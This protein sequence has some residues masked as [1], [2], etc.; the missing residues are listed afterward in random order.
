[1]YEYTLCKS[2]DVLVGN[3]IKHLLIISLFS[4][5]IEFSQ[6]QCTNV[7]CDPHHQLSLS[8][9]HSGT[10]N[11]TDCFSIF[12]YLLVSG[13]GFDLALLRDHPFSRF[14]FLFGDFD[15]VLLK[16]LQAFWSIALL[17]GSVFPSNYNFGSLGSASLLSC[18]CIH[19]VQSDCLRPV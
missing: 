8:Y 2:C 10:C 11:L 16:S 1:M 5:Y 19:A 3:N 9:R 12:Y 13:H 4:Q 15:K 17:L 6:N 7:G 14:C 18:A